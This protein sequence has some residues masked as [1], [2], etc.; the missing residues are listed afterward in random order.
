MD[1]IISESTLQDQYYYQ[2]C[3]STDCNNQ[4]T[5]KIPV[6]AGKFGIIEICVCKSCAPKFQEDVN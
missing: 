1:N 4:A 5:E 2:T 6:A 3:N